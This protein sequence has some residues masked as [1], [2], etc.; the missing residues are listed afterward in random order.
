MGRV[1]SWASSAGEVEERRAEA[2]ALVGETLSEVRYFTL[3]YKRDELARDHS[4]PRLITSDFEWSD[5]CWASEACD[6]LEYGVELQTADGVTF[7]V[8]WDPP[9]VQE[10]IGIQAQPLGTTL[11]PEAEIAM[12]EVGVRSRWFSAIGQRV[13]D[14]DLHYIP[15]T[16]DGG[17]FWC[18]RITVTFDDVPVVLML[19]EASE[20][21]G[22]GP[23]ADNVAVL[24]EPHA[25]PDWALRLPFTA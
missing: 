3:D 18:P 21:G 5:P 17:D 16:R 24:F 9:G 15:W 7:S 6:S 13:A 10:G 2:R 20:D 8:T 12:W 14:V 23:S 25:V 22:I 1:W 11:H 19:G 4:G